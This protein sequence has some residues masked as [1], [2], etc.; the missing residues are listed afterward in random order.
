[1]ATPA[2]QRRDSARDALGLV[3]CRLRDDD[4]GAQ[5]LLSR[6]DTRAMASVL[7]A[8]AALL[9]MRHVDDPERL[10]NRFREAYG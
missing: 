8:M 2:E 6:G 7:S 1:M 10:L 9:L 3:G 5:Y 4:A